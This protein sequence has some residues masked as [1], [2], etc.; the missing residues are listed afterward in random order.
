MVDTLKIVLIAVF[1][2]Y[3]IPLWA[4]RYQFRSAVYKDTSWA[5]N[6]RPWFW[7]ETVSLFSNKYLQ[8]TQE[9]KIGMKY[10][11]YLT[12]HVLLFVAILIV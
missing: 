2:V 7:K 11:I 9:R 10:R 1:F 3:G 8:T 12:I 4:L 5:I 6:V